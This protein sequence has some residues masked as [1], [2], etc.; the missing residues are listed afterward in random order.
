MEKDAN[1]VDCGA[2]GVIFL[3]YLRGIALILAK[4]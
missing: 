1:E 4:R 3:P 2:G